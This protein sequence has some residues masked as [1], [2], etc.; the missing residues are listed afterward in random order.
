ML[1]RS[2]RVVWVGMLFLLLPLS[3]MAFYSSN[4]SGSTVQYDP[5]RLVV[6]MKSHIDPKIVM[7]QK[8]IV[9]TGVEAFDQLNRAF[10]VREQS[11]VFGKSPFAR[12]DA[13]LRNVFVLTVDEGVDVFQ[14]KDAYEKLESVEYA[15]PDY[16]V[17]LYD[18]PNDP[19]YSN[20]TVSD[21]LLTP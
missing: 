3:S 4:D 10:D 8:G 2:L 20:V 6:K 5:T 1:C 11:D 13:R 9:Q 17:E 19:L 16:R 15:Y 7:N 12:M 21:F 18:T 14:M